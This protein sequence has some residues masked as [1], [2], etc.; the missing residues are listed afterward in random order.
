MYEPAE[1]IPVSGVANDVKAT[2]LLGGEFEYNLLQGIVAWC[3]FLDW[4]YFV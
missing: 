1:T 4:Y 2:V 3:L